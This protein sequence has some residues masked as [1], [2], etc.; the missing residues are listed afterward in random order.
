MNLSKNLSKIFP[1]E[2]FEEQKWMIMSL[3]SL[4]AFFLIFPFFTQENSSNAMQII[5]LGA[6]TSALYAVL[7][8]GFSLI[9]GVAKQ[10]KLSLGGYYV[11]GA[12]S[13]YF[14]LETARISPSASL[15]SNIDGFLLLAL[16]LLP[17]ILMVALLAFFWTIFNVREFIF[18]LVSLIIAS[19]AIIFKA[20]F[21]EGL[22]SGL[23]VL[24]L[25]LAAW[26]LELPK[27]EVAVGTFIF[28]VMI[29]ILSLID[30]PADYISLMILA[31]MFTAFLALI[32]D[33][34]ILDRFRASHVNTMI[35]T[36]SMALLLQ[37]IIQIVVF[38]SNGEL[39]EQFGPEDRTLRTILPKE[40]VLLLVNLFGVYIDNIR[41]ISLIL[42]IFACI[43]LYAFIW[44]SK[45]GMALRAVAQD[46]EAAALAG[47]DIRKTTS[48]VSAIGMG[49][50]AYAAVMTSSFSAMPTWSPYMG[51][52]VLIMAIAVVTL[53][54]MGSL[55]GSII[56]A[57]I[58]GYAEVLISSI[59]DFAPFSVVIPF[60]VV[61][62]VMIFKPEGLIGEKKELEG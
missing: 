51:W 22:Y 44:F 55:P 13:M 37:S 1:K 62:L 16:I 5:L 12:Y 39:L 43:L 53:G 20:G 33:R 59:P 49:L 4:F 3:I 6:V 40:S 54:G 14:L 58:I 48:I 36:F 19:G 41:I 50:I 56:A 31:I 45:M 17:I 25:G 8:L 57:F 10:L 30:F 21:V 34:F 42:S 61:L 26:Y 24:I 27:R 9:Y 11:V 46:E 47:I 35:V 38:P 23:A 2:F 29:L 60:I 18:I 52:W 15:L 7:A 32:T 28:G